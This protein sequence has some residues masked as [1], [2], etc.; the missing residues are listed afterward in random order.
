VLK[1]YDSRF[2]NADRKYNSLG[3]IKNTRVYEQVEPEQ[4]GTCLEG[5]VYN[6]GL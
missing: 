3:E 5:L 1:V 6:R 4:V 2:E